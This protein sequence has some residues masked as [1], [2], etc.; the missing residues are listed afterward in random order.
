MYVYYI[1]LFSIGTGIRTYI[2][3]ICVILVFYINKKGMIYIM[4]ITP[5][6][7]FIYRY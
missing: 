5:Y 7:L 6:Y 4:Y 3:Y 2:L 1:F